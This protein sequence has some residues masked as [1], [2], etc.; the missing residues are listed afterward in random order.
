MDE[1][2]A[3]LLAAIAHPDEDTPRLALADWLDEHG[4]GANCARAEFIRLQCRIA[5]VTDTSPK[6]IQLLARAD[7]LLN[8]H[9]RAWMGALWDLTGDGYRDRDFTRGFLSW[10]YTTAGA[11]V[12]KAHQKAVCERFP[13]LGVERLM[14]TEKSIRVKAIADSPRRL[15]WVSEFVWQRSQLTDDGFRALV[16]SPHTSRTSVLQ[17]DR[18]YCGDAAL[19]ASLAKSP[20]WPNL[21][22]LRP[23]RKGHSTAGTRTAGVLAVLNKR[24]HAAASGLS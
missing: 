21:R 18:A 11:F 14:L 8:T 9:A 17:I 12:K 20:N 10:W 2:R 13:V 5:R 19:R 24:G 23:H 6:T 3:L 7:D 15:G 4:D 1:R 22:R 16:A